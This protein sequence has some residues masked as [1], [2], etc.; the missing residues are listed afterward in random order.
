[1]NSIYA[2]KIAFRAVG[3]VLLLS[4][5]V[6]FGRWVF[7]KETET[8]RAKISRPAEP[9][10]I[11]E[12]SIRIVKDDYGWTHYYVY[13]QGR[14][15]EYRRVSANGARI[16]CWNG[17]KW[18]RVSSHIAR[19]ATGWYGRQNWQS[20]PKYPSTTHR[21]TTPGTTSY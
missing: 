13:L 3:V 8:A 21:G 20:P 11:E 12:Y 7:H 14:W 5:L 19:P 2:T 6:W 15:N 18:I 1:M 9:P 10:E 16:Y 17:R 4:L